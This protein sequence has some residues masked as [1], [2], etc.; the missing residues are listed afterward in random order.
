MLCCP[1][2]YDGWRNLMNKKLTILVSG[3]LFTE[4]ETHWLRG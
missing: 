3:I 1:S 2:K 4:E